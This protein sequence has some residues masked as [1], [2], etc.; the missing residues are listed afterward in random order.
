MS[1][2][3]SIGNGTLTAPIAWESRSVTR[4]GEPL[5]H[6][7]PIGAA[8]W[9]WREARWQGAWQAERR[10]PGRGCAWPRASCAVRQHD[11]RAGGAREAILWVRTLASMPRIAPWRAGYSIN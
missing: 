6:A 5:L 1:F 3:R 11:A 4:Q 7:Q 8:R 10:Q 2:V 9:L